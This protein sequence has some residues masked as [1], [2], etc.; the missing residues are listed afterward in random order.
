M[1]G[2]SNAEDSKETL[3]NYLEKHNA[4]NFENNKTCFKSLDNPSCIDLLITSQF[5]CFLNTIQLYFPQAFHINENNNERSELKSIY[6][7]T[8]TQDSIKSYKNPVKVLQ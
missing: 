4:A 7:K 5:R 8:E 6:L 3:L 2:N 1:I